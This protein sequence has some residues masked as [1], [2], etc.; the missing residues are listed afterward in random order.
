MHRINW[1][2]LLCAALLCGLTVMASAQSRIIVSVDVQ[3]RNVPVTLTVQ[4]AEI[5]DVLS[6]LFNATNNTYQL[7]TGLG[8][9]GTIDTLQL[10]RIPFDDAVTAILAKVNPTFT[11]SK[12]DGDIYCVT[13][14]AGANAATPVPT[15]FKPVIND[16]DIVIS[17]K[18][19]L[20]IIKDKD[21]KPGD[22]KES[23]D[24][25]KPAAPDPTAPDPLLGSDD[26]ATG[27]KTGKDAAKTTEEC[28]LA[29]IKIRNQPVHVFAVGFGADELPD[30][31]TLANPGGTTGTGIGGTGYNGMTSPYG[32][33]PYGTN[34]YGTT[35]PYGTSYP[36]G[37]TSPYG[38]AYPYGTSS[39]YG[40][41]Y[42]YGTVATPVTTTTTGTTTGGR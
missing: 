35:S 25:T 23:K 40:T 32:T 26:T 34:P 17:G 33:S 2:L 31:S 8:I 20:P 7:Q 5:N 30:F 10:T 14:P 39:P 38:T 36:Y 28:Y 15:L 6:A 24:K 29:M 3:A 12:A 22:A 16:P 9:S 11:Y 41:G 21:A 1:L 42:P 13:N 4:N 19:V 18:L 27:D 37:T